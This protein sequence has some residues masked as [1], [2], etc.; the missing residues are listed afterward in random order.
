M[1]FWCFENTFR[2]RENDFQLRENTFWFRRVVFQVHVMVFSFG[3]VMFQ[4]RVV[5]F[6]FRAGVFQVRAGDVEFLRV[7][8]R[9][10]VVIGHGRPVRHAA[11]RGDALS[12]F[13][14]LWDEARV[15]GHIPVAV[16]Q[17]ASVE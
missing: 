15:C 8:V 5:A 17:T 10:P 14:E 2:F 7:A 12:C 6:W 11:F 16:R 3:V 1:T 9:V 13:S 4:V